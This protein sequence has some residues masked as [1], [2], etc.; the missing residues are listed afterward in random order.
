[1]RRERAHLI[2]IGL[3]RHILIGRVRS[4]A[5]ANALPR[6]LPAAARENTRHLA[7]KHDIIN[8]VL[9]PLLVAV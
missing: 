7:N 8:L 2:R 1:M 9:A 5:A 4:A 6:T 3:H